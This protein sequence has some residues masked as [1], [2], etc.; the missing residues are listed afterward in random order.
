MKFLAGIQ[1]E[2]NGKISWASGMIIWFPK[3]QTKVSV[4]TVS[5]AG[6]EKCWPEL[7]KVGTG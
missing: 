4:S 3:C 5:E 7:P 6:E 1:R 2:E